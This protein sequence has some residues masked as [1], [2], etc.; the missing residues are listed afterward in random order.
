MSSRPIVISVS[1]E[2]RRLPL[3]DR[4]GRDEPIWKVEDQP[5]LVSTR[6]S[7]W[8]G[9]LRDGKPTGPPACDVPTNGEETAAK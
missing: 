3:I 5:K 4:L 6:I 8:L 2:L 1:L 7:A 9:E